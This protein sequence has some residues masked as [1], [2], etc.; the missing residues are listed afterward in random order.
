MHLAKGHFITLEGGEGAGKSSLAEAL[1][2]EIRLQ[3]QPV[4]RTREPG[5]TP[6]ADRIR[7][8]LVT[9]STQAFSPLTEALLFTAARNDHLETAIRPALERG[10]WVICDRYLDSTEAYQAAA[11]GIAAG[12]CQD[13]AGLINAPMP[14]LTLLLDVEPGLG[15]ARSRGASLGEDRFEGRGLP[16]HQAVRAAFLAIATREPQRIT[17]IKA[18][19]APE[20]I[21]A[22]ALMALH[23]RGW[24]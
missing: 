14:D 2:Q 15:L 1:A 19:Q 7:Q 12:V 22:Q 11:G 24:L 23:A 16:F 5:G 3:G 6:A 20:A 9:R 17:L 4:L 8:V 13:L 18:D 21:L 10:D